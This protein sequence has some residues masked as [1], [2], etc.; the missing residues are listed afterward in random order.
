MRDRIFPQGRGARFGADYAKKL[1]AETA[2]YKDVENVHDLP[3]I[4]HYWSNAH[5]RP[6]LEQFG[7]SNPDQFFAKFLRESAQR[8]Q[9][10]PAR[11]VSVGCGNCDTE[12][13]VATLLLEQGFDDFVIECVD[14]NPHMLARGNELAAAQGVSRHISTTMADFNSWKP[15]HRYDG[16]IANQSLHHVVDLERLFDT[17]RRCLNE[18]GYF[19]TSDIIGRNGHMRW[20]EA[21]KEVNALWR[22]LPE[23][24]HYNH[25]LRRMEAEYENWDCSKEGFEGIR[26]QDVLPELLKRFNFKLFIGFA[27]VV[28]LFVDRSFGHNFDANDANDRAFVDRAH[29]I[30]E[31]GFQSGTLTPTHMMAVMSPSDV[32][33][34]CARGVTPQRSLHS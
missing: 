1:A 30:D 6:M 10:S 15:A 29:A 19:I 16:V 32:D 5:L 21:L 13:R 9:R 12:V 33:C 31:A 24:Y 2:N 7:F 25:Q 11:F 26:A 8:C 28:D 4:F 3:E 34:I 23:R 22:E 14:M 27:N 18:R 20:P 17:I